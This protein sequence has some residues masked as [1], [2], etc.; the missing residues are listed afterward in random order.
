MAYSTMALVPLILSMLALPM[1]VDGQEITL[2]TIRKA[3]QAREAKVRS[4]RFDWDVRYTVPKG[5][6]RNGTK[7]DD[8][9]DGLVIPPETTTYNMDFR[10]SLDG[11]KVRYDANE[12]MLS[13]DRR[14]L[15][16]KSYFVG[17]NEG[18]KSF[19]PPG[20][21]TYPQGVI[22]ERNPERIFIS[23]PQAV[24]LFLI[25]R[26]LDARSC[27]FDDFPEQYQ[28]L[29]G[30][31]VVEGRSCVQIRE[32]ATSPSQGINTMWL[33]G[34]R[35]FV[36]MRMTRSN[37]DGPYVQVTFHDFQPSKD[38]W[39]PLRWT[40]VVLGEG[41]SVRSS[42][43]ATVRSWQL[44]VRFDEKEFDVELPPG[45]L[46]TEFI[47]SRE[48]NYIQR[49]AGRKR[50]VLEKEI[51]GGATYEQLLHT[52]SGKALEN[53]GL[54]GSKGGW[55]GFVLAGVLAIVLLVAFRWRKLRMVSPRLR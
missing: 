14:L 51:L 30:R 42:T 10:L 32:I 7:N 17:T 18:S 4:F 21:G 24:P 49:E 9:P 8:N 34:D 37:D 39:V 20:A 38:G 31:S 19:S 54:T 27:I 23:S 44:N 26:P 35:E 50:P 2:E 1:R 13:E 25:Y 55:T 12:M 6:Y 29:P 36:V 28:V 5:S 11:D 53:Q 16:Q 15:H 33:D 43:S 40:R 45:T 22:G 41:G 47:G 3:W 46:V 48:N 52:E